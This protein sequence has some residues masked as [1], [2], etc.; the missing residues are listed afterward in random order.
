MRDAEQAAR[1]ILRTKAPTLASVDD[2]V[3]PFRLRK[4]PRVGDL[5]RRGL[6]GWALGERRAILRLDVP[7]P[8][9][10]LEHQANGVRIVSL[11]D[12]DEHAGVHET[13]CEFAIHDLTHLEKFF[14]PSHHHGQ[15]GF[16]RR[17]RAAMNAPTWADVERDLEAQAWSVARDYVMSDMN[18]SAVFLWVA[19]RGRLKQAVLSAGGTTEDALARA[20][21]L[22]E[23]FAFND[24][25]GDALLVAG[26]HRTPEAATSIDAF[27]RAS[28]SHLHRW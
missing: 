24:L 14:D 3:E 25:T 8:H 26:G 2:P 19:L 23:L 22:A 16:F 9:E 28:A 1:L 20:R 21:L 7:Q 18:G 10:M 5:A 17:L 13:A 15:V 6:I 12:S 4:V 11:L 27:F